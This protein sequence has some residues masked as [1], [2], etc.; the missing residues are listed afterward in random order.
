MNARKIAIWTTII[1]LAAGLAAVSIYAAIT[2]REKEKYENQIRAVRD[3]A[4]QELQEDVEALSTQLLKLQATADEEQ[5][6]LLLMDIWKGTGNT[7]KS[8]SMLP[9]SY[10]NSEK[11]LGFINT[12][13]DY[14]YQLAMKIVSGEE[15]DAD[16][17]IKSLQRTCRQLMDHIELARQEGEQLDLNKDVNSEDYI[18]TEAE[19]QFTAQE[20]PRLIYDGPYSE[21]VQQAQAKSLPSYTIT[22]QA[23]QRKAAEF[24]AVEPEEIEFLEGVEGKIP[25][26]CLGGTKDGKDFRIAITKQGGEILWFTMDTPIGMTAIPTDDRT[27]ELEKIA[28]RYLSSKGYPVCMLSYC[29]FYDGNAIFNLVPMKGKVKLYPDL[30]KVWVNLES[31]EVVGMDATNYI[32]SHTDRNLEEPE[33]SEDDAKKNLSSQL[34][35]ENTAMAVIPLDTGKEAYC[36]EFQC[37]LSEQDCLVYIDTQTGKQRDI[38]IIQHTNEGTL[39]E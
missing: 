12:M 7:E 19:T 33:I 23:A 20:I 15:I 8:V 5:E 4:Y 1:V 17:E 18:P 13:G 34:K 14:S 10:Q 32:M 38:L 30:I 21:S 25:V 2:E 3:Y 27:E 39:V 24:M 35:V 36:Y 6:I 22:E 11:L 37:S 31:S 9:I 28:E 16:T 26:Y 29:Q